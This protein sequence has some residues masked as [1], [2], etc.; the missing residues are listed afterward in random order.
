M[1]AA[2]V[3]IHLVELHA[4]TFRHIAGPGRYFS[5]SER[6]ALAA[7]ARGTASCA[8]CRRRKLELVAPGG[9]HTRACDST[10]PPAA[11]ELAH[12]VAFEPGRL[13]RAYYDSVVPRLLSDAEWVEVVG[14]VS[15][16]VSIDF[17]NRALGIALDPLPTPV[18]GEPSRTRPA[19]VRNT[20]AWVPMLAPEDARGPEADLYP[21]KGVPNVIRALSLVPEEARL[22]LELT[23]HHYVGM[24]VLEM[25]YGRA[26]GRSQM[27]LL[28]GRVS[29]LNEC[30]Y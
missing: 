1:S 3:P 14:V 22:V 17:F 8:L 29:V 23:E 5:G 7:E 10:L 27:E 21:G 11:V 4:A 9:E 16:T 26:L 18:P 28:A 19:G 2:G 15:K 13:S 6:V 30:F 12:R 25:D 20:G 24:H